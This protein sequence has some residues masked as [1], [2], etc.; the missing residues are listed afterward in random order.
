MTSKQALI[1]II[2]VV[3]SI[4]CLFATWVF[5]STPQAPLKYCTYTTYYD[6][7]GVHREIKV[8]PMSTTYLH[9]ETQNHHLVPVFDYAESKGLYHDWNAR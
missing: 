6:H 4:T 2:T 8:C 3:C 9:Y 7:E 1:V 5:R